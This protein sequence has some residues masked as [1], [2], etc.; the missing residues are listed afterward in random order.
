MRHRP[1]SLFRGSELP[2][3]LILVAIV[4]AGW[5]VCLMFARSDEP[6]KPAP[7]VVPVAKITPIVPDNSIEF[8]AI[9]D[10]TPVQ[11]RESAAYAKL[12]R[13]ARE[14]SAA[15]LSKEARRDVFFTHLWERPARYRGVPI[16]LTGM[17][18]KIL[19]YEVAPTMTP[20][21]RLYEIWFYSDENRS[22]PYVLV[23][24]DPPAGLAVGHELNLP[25]TVDGYFFKLMKYRAGDNY[26]GAPMLVG[27]MHWTPAAPAAPSTMTELSKIPK[28][29]LAIG[30]FALFVVYM[31]IRLTLQFRRARALARPRSSL[32]SASH[33]GVP[34]E[35]LAEWLQ[36]LPE[37]AED[38][39]AD[40]S[41]LL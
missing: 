4:L 38:E 39:P 9:Q 21:E 6:V 8:Q 20:A 37:E 35:Q 29:N 40:R 26:R 41:H 30:V 28:V 1:S 32:T 19:T 17:A 18:K 3:L 15:D 25:I 33:D 10:M 36:Q 16:H 23:I 12:L 2:R 11:T 27:R 13:M 5:P 24:Q 7:A 22:F 34:A 31:G 14:T